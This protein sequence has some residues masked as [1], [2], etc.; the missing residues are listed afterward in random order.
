MKLIFEM[1]AP[2]RGSELLPVCKT[3]YKSQ[4]VAFRKKNASPAGGVRDRIEP[5]LYG[6]RETDAWCQ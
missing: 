6:A 3:P 1:G 5:P 4:K 2:G